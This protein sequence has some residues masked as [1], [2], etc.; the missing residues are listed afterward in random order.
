MKGPTPG[1]NVGPQGCGGWPAIYLLAAQA[2]S[3]A[4]DTCSDDWLPWSENRGAAWRYLAPS[5]GLIGLPTRSLRL[6]PEVVQAPSG[7]EMELGRSGADFVCQHFFE[8]GSPLRRP[9]AGLE[10]HLQNPSSVGFQ[11]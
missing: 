3:D 1:E 6:G 2:A 5:L 9:H 4:D 11:E 8:C 7:H 10:T